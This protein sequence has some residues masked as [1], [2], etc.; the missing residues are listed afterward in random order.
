MSAAEGMFSAPIAASWACTARS[1][2]SKAREI[3][4]L[5]NWFSSRSWAILPSASSL[6]RAS[7]SRR[8]SLS[9]MQILS[10]A[11]YKARVELDGIG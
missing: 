7:L 1:R 3:A 9:F 5:T 2:A 10:S 11:W 6:E 4:L 8:P